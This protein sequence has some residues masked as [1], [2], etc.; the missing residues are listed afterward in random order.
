MLLYDAGC[1]FCRFTALIVIGLDRRKDLAVLPLQDDAATALLAGLPDGERLDSWRLARR[2]GS[3]AGDGSGMPDLLE[4]MRLTRPVGRF[5]RVVPAPVLD[6][7]YRLVARHRGRLGRLAPDRP[8][9]R[10]FP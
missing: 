2:D 5:L 3:L 7:L 1:R 9:P 10:R 4:A 8:G 6:R